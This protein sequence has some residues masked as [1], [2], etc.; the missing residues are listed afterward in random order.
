MPAGVEIKVEIVRV[1]E[2]VGLQEV[3]L[4]EAVAPEGRPDAA[5]ETD[6]VTPLTS[7]KVIVFESDAP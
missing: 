4:K 2:Q 6:S 3:G 5:R 1:L 7:V